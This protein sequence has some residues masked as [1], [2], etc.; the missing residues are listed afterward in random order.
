MNEQEIA[1][2]LNR[3]RNGENLSAAERRWLDSFYVHQAKKSQNFL[4]DEELQ[5]NLGK[6]EWG[7]KRSIQ[8]SNRIRRINYIRIAA[9]SVLAILSFGYLFS[10]GSFDREK[11]IELSNGQT[12]KLVLE[13]GTTVILN[14]S[15]KLSYPKTFENAAQ[16]E[17]TLVGEAYFDV[18]KDSKKPFRIHTPRMEIRVLGT[19][20]NVRDYREDKSAETS[21]VRGRVEIWKTGITDNKFVLAP[22]QKF[23]TTEPPQANDQ[24]NVKS[25]EIAS[26]KTSSNIQ[27]FVISEKDGHA[28]ETEWML[29]RI[30]IQN[31]P[32]AQIV[33]R[34]E[35][36][37]GI[38]ITI[39]DK[40]IAN[41]L[42]SATF[43]NERIDNVLKGLQA[44][45][46]F[47]YR[48]VAAGHIEIY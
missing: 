38:Q 17:V 29:K 48:T 41:Q 42:Y 43:D 27:T 3:Y 25:S 18:A 6:V 32:L 46:P 39:R 10:I 5:T 19:A 44:V 11:V 14:A 16:R 40:R 34:L 26:P 31:E 12:K 22:R 2:L 20:F 36:M 4:S 35:R 21:L 23:V 7:L 8:R 13:D 45:S 9:A 24:H 47:Q 33:R 1:D 37:Y 30:T 28:V 15:S